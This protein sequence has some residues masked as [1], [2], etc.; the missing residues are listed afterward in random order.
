VLYK[1]GT[2]FSTILTV[3]EQAMAKWREDEKIDKLIEWEEKNQDEIKL[4]EKLYPS[5]LCGDDKEGRPV[6]IARMG[7]IAVKEFIKSFSKEEWRM[8][9]K[10]RVEKTIVNNP[11][12][13]RMNSR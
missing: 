3:F 4:A 6:V 2:V 13:H 5:C 7:K 9:H 10:W 11:D 12:Q 1:I 8:H